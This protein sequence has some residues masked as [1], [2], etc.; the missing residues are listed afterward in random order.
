MIT[1]D[2]LIETYHISQD[3]TAIIS[4]FALIM[5]AIIG[6]AL[7]RFFIKD[8]KKI[9]FKNF[10]VGAF[11]LIVILTIN[12][13]LINDISDHD[14]S[15]DEKK[16]KNEYLE[17]YI[18]SQPFNKLEIN[19]FSQI[20]NEKPKGITSVYLNEKITPQWFFI[21]TKEEKEYKIQAIIKKENIKNPYLSFKKI[22]KDISDKYNKESY[23]ETVL[24]VPLEYK[25]ISTY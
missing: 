15:L 20:V 14:F 4:I 25:V 11:F 3:S 24:Y 7:I 13:F 8:R 5:W 17:P 12:I 9:N 19:D 23:Y 16:W 1:I 2:Q 6:Y 10:F 22:E 18:E 21:K